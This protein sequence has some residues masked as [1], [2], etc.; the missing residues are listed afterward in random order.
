MA[1][2]QAARAATAAAVSDPRTIEQSLGQLDV[3]NVS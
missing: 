3:A 1:S 2:P